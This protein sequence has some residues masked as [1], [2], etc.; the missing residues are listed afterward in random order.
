[1]LLTSDLP[2]VC[3]D[4]KKREKVEGNKK[5]FHVGAGAGRS[6]AEINGLRKGKT[7]ADVA[8]RQFSKIASGQSGRNLL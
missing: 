1:M 5:N 2:S 8:P 4:P 7:A 3:I 6:C